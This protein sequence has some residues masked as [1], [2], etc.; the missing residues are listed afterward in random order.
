MIVAARNI[1]LGKNGN[2]VSDI[3]TELI[4]CRAKFNMAV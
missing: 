1:H 4:N 3:K 2:K